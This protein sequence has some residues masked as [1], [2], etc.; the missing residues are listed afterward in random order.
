MG[1]SMSSA[2]SI[3]PLL[4]TLTSPWHL[5]AGRVPAKDCQDLQSLGGSQD[6][7]NLHMS[8]TAHR[9]LVKTRTCHCSFDYACKLCG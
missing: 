4:S 1:M 6:Q 5:R 7:K 8:G 2:N 3:M 9:R